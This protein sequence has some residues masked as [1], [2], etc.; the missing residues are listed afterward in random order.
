MT[1]ERPYRA[2]RTRAQAIVELRRESGM[3]F[4]PDIVN[5]FIEIL[6]SRA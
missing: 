6:R 4:D 3:Q 5:A 1:S 2:K